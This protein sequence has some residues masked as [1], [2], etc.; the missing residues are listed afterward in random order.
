MSNT[1]KQ[2]FSANQ[3][4]VKFRQWENDKA[5]QLDNSKSLSHRL[6]PV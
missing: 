4:I 1:G 3:S 2:Q 6:P 5:A